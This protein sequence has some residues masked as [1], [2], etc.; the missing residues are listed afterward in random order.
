MEQHIEDGVLEGVCDEWRGKGLIQKNGSHKQD[1]LVTHKPIDH[2]GQ[3][4]LLKDIQ[5]QYI[6]CS[7]K[8]ATIKSF[9]LE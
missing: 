7:M 9:H 6:G 4:R 5:K 2:G 3:Q 1:I 8:I